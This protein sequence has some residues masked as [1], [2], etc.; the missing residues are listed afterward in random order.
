[1]NRQHGFS[2]IE[3]L[4]VVAI[5]LIIAGLAI[6]SLLRSRMSANEA[7]TAS[8]L[9]TIGTANVLYLS[10]FRN[11]YAGSLAE[12][13]PPGGSCASVGS[14]CA[15]LIDATLSGVNPATPSPLKS[16]YRFTYYIPS[17]TPSPTSPNR[18]WAIVATPV[19][20][21]VSGHS[22]FCF[23]HTNVL[24]KDSSG[25]TTTA[26]ASGCSPTWTAGGG[27]GPN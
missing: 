27:I 10:L 20:S 11:G 4:I 9:K 17:P 8:A 7:V 24:W 26:T 18:T 13:G 16:G 19:S 5:I 2:I 3:L 15:D 12:L 14:G 21:D 6:P 22:T 23:D 25:A 1:M